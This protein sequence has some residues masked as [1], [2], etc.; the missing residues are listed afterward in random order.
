MQNIGQFAQTTMPKGRGSK[1]SECPCKRNT[2]TIIH[3]D[4]I[5]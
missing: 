1:G 3:T 5:E 2:S 4:T